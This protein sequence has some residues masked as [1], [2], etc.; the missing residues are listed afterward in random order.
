MK[1]QT[2]TIKVFIPT[3]CIQEV[4]KL[5][6]EEKV[7]HGPIRRRFLGYEIEVKDGPMASYLALK[8]K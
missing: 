7:W 4:S 8:F 6:R 3:N 5:L 2:S 1:I